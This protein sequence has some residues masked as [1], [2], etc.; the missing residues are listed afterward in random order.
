MTFK[1]QLAKDVENVFFNT[2]E[3]ANTVVYQ[4]KTGGN[5]TV[6]ALIEYE[7][8]L[9]TDGYG[10]SEVGT[11]MVKRSDVEKPTYGDKIVISGY[12]WTVYH[13]RWANPEAFSL[14]IRRD[15]RG[16]V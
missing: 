10:A 16:R 7:T 13:I 12:Y 4:P 2:D 6:D 15:E 9:D 11:I 8:V 5:I 14:E 3:G 1:A